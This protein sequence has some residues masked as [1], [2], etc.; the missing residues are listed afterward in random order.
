MPTQDKKLDN[1]IEKSFPASD[2]VSV[3]KPTGTEPPRRPVD[4]LPPV[5]TKDQVE[6]AERGEGHA[7]RDHDDEEVRHQKHH[8][9]GDAG[10]E[11]K[12]TPKKTEVDDHAGLGSGS[13]RST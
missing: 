4:R 9:L 3:A 12:D 1:A 11:A 6:A 7:Q 13:S 8:G 10:L 2:P 5:I